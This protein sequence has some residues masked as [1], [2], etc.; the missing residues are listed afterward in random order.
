M[1]GQHFK[2]VLETICK[3]TNSSKSKVALVSGFNA[4]NFYDWQ[5]KGVPAGKTP[6]V[7]VKLKDYLFRRLGA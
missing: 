7:M 1:T 4:H 2:E 3:S 6:L 5:R